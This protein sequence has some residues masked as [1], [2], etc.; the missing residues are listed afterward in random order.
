MNFQTGVVI[1]SLFAISDAFSVSSFSSRVNQRRIST[2]LSMS[3][4]KSGNI[5]TV[6]Y[7]P[8]PNGDFVPSPLF[9][10]GTVTFALDE[11]NYIPG[12]HKIAG[13][14]E[15]GES[16]DDVLLDAGWGERKAELVA[17]VPID[18]SGMEKESLKV[19]MELYLANGM[20]CKITEIGDDNFTI[21]ANPPLAGA[22][23]TSK[24]TLDKIEK[25]PS[26]AKFQYNS[27]KVEDDSEYDVLTIALGCFWGGELEYMRVAGVVKTTVG[28]TQGEKDEPSYKEVCS[29]NTGHTEAIQVVFD[30]RVVSYEKLVSIGMERLGESKFLKNQVGN[31]RGTQ[32]RHGVYYHNDEQK[33][34]ALK[35]I[36]SYGERCVT[37]CKEA[38]KYY[39]AEDYHLQYLLKG[40]Q[41][42]RKNA[43]ESIRC[44]G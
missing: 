11:G 4:P 23:Y 26:A 20:S 39:T 36:G 33:E 30:P 35:V 22:T 40:G 17:Q 31:D 16:V 28:Y 13:S 8:K 12:L 7:D 42:A 9:D 10:D 5:V 3:K 18:S 34:V 41:S 44:Y 25:A 1:L 27:K 24:V 14:L 15:E 6:T 38:M 43:K 29:G 21:D 2:E 19:G 37:E 32:Y